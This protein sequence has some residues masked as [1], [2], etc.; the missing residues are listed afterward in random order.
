M[1][2]SS[3]LG[4]VVAILAGTCAG[5][6]GIGYLMR[7]QTLTEV[8]LLL[9]AGVWLTR[10]TFALFENWHAFTWAIS[11]C[12]VIAAAGAYLLERMDTHATSKSRGSSASSGP[13]PSS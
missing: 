13:A 1:F 5:L 10:V 11:G 2:G 4:D 7:S 9:G 6:L 8:G 12:W 3:W